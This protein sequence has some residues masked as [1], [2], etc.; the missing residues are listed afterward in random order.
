MEIERIRNNVL[1]PKKK[2]KLKEPSKYAVFMMNDDYSPMDFVTEML[3]KHFGHSEDAAISIML[4]VHQKGKGVAGIYTRDI[5]ETKA[6]FCQDDAIA[7]GHPLKVDFEKL[8]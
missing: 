3:V 2:E 5:A 4:D 1:E 6:Q 8:P 7:N